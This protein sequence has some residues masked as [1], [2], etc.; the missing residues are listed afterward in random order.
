MGFLREKEWNKVE[1]VNSSYLRVVESNLIF[2][3]FF[4]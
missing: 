1:N 3:Y 4:L 2:I